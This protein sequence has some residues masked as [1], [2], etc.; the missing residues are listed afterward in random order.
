[1]D[2]NFHNE[3]TEY[4]MF[5]C[6]VKL[7]IDTIIYE[8]LMDCIINIFDIEDE[9]ICNLNLTDGNDNNI[10]KN[11]TNYKWFESLNNLNIAIK[12]SSLNFNPKNI[13][14]DIGTNVH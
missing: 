9:Q 8:K 2:Y 3:Y 6:F 5:D 13:G 11:L 12:Q 14:I 4:V 10:V 7:H 1:M